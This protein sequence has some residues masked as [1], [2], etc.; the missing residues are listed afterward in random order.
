M[1]QGDDGWCKQDRALEKC[2]H[3]ARC[4]LGK[5]R[6]MLGKARCM[7]CKRNENFLNDSENSCL[8]S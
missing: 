7:V 3:K 5:T 4:M 1:F 2:S 8:F 6:S